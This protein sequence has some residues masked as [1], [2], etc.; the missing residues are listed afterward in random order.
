MDLFSI[1]IPTY[2]GE[3][4]LA[5]ALESLARQTYENI[6]VIV[7]DDNG[8]DTADQL[9]T[10]AVVDSF[11]DRLNIVYLPN[12]HVNG[13]HARNEGLKVAKGLY[14]A[15]LDDDDFYLSDHVE[16][17]VQ[18]FGETDADMVFFSVAILTR[19]GA[20]R[21][22][23]NKEIN[24][25]DLLYYRKEIGSGSNLCFRR[26]V[27]DEDGGFD[28]R[29]LRSQDIEFAVKKLNRY[30]SVWIDEIKIVKYFNRTD[31]FPDYRKSLDN[32]ELLCKDMC[33]SGIISEK[34]RDELYLNRL[35]SFYNDL[36]AK[37]APKDDIKAVY[38]LL[39]DKGSL[40]FRDKG[41]MAVYVISKPLFEMIFKAYLSMSKNEDTSKELLE[42]R[43][44]LEVRR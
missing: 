17:A 8:K 40:S 32:Y 2:K 6:E 7:S 41:M 35:H 27:Y 1:V 20:Q 24:A 4:S 33:E 11:K 13:S 19:E 15:L 26:R 43:K 18:A 39:K 29:Y 36:L 38:A 22:I 16:K 30:K 21:I 44:E 3:D 10:E 14:I 25:K 31:N 34:G 23:R 42:L 37:G 9:R 28:E 5:V 12:E